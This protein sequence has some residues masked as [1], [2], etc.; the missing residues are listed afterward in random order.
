[1]L[2]P[3]AEPKQ[4][5][6]Q[7]L[8]AALLGDKGQQRQITP[9]VV[10]SVEEGQLLLAVRRIDSRIQI[11]IDMLCLLGQL[12][13]RRL[14]KQSPQPQELLGSKGVL[15]PRQRGLACQSSRRLNV[16]AAGNPQTGIILERVEIVAVLVSCGNGIDALLEEGRKSKTDLAGLSA[17]PKRTCHLVRKSEALVRLGNKEQTGVGGQVA[18]IETRADTSLPYCRK[19]ERRRRNHSGSSFLRVLVS[20]PHNS[21]KGLLLPAW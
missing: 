13:N 8:S 19:I 20:S 12:R 10:M 21:Q 7:M 1:V 15:E 14:R 6:H 3:Q 16:L 5:A 11:R 17:F 9:G 4:G 18:P 2:R